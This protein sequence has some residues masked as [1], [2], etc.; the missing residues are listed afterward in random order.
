VGKLTGNPVVG[1][2][3]SVGD[4]DIT[5][6][7]KGARRPGCVPIRTN[8]PG[9]LVIRIFMSSFLGLK[10]A[11]KQREEKNLLTHPKSARQNENQQEPYGI[12]GIREQ[13]P[14]KQELINK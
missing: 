4:H 9:N 5:P 8:D 3:A 11:R 2:S 10:Y 14:P 13:N 6:A 7:F 12:Y 1:Y